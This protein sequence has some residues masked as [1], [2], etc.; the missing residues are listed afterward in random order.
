VER[1]I[2][3]TGIPFGADEKILFKHFSKCG[4]IEAGRH[5]K[6]HDLSGGTIITRRDNNGIIMG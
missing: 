1:T 3:V 6:K 2:V 5:G 4:L